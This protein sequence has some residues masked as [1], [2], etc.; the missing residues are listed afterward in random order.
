MYMYCVYFSPGKTSESD[1]KKPQKEWPIDK[2]TH[3]IKDYLPLLHKQRKTEDP[4]LI[5]QE[6]LK[7]LRRLLKKL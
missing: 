4:E 6:N 7:T 1:K 2:I 5:R 3:E